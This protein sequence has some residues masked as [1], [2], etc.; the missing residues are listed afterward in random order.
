MTEYLKDKLP[1]TAALFQ[2]DKTKHSDH[3]RH[4]VGGGQ[5]AHKALI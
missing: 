5:R 3:L 2:I 4:P 1:T